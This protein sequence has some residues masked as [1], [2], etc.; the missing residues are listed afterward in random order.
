MEADQPK[1]KKKY[2]L[3]NSVV[4]QNRNN[5][6]QPTSLLGERKEEKRAE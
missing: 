6:P 4:N 1:K 2:V 3:A 5:N